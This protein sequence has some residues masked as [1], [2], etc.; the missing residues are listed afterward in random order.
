ME[1]TANT[2]V[3]LAGILAGVAA[4]LAG[5]VVVGVPLIAICLWGLMTWP[6]VQEKLDAARPYEGPATRA[7]ADGCSLLFI[8]AAIVVGAVALMGALGL[9]AGGVTP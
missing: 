4:C 9:T 3:C 5:G 7:E 1:G 8:L 6:G 2:V